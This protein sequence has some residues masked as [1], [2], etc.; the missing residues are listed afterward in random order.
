MVSGVPSAT[1]DVADAT[2]ALPTRA[3]IE[4]LFRE[5][6]DAKKGKEDG[7][8]DLDAF[9]QTLLSEGERLIAAHQCKG[10]RFAVAEQDGEVSLRPR[11]IR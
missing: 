1:G 6:V 11:L 8:L 4:A 2:P 9:A 7:D 3:E 5:F 10:V